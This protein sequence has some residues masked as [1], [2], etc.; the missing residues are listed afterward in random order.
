MEL[1]A[2]IINYDLKQYLTINKN[3]GLRMNET[4]IEFK[5]LYLSVL[6]KQAQK[7]TEEL[8][9]LDENQETFK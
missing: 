1:G 4:N 6:Y 2:T 3:G 9:S 8:K 5:K 7:I